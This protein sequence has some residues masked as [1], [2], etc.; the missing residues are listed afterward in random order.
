MKLIRFIIFISHVFLFFSKN[1]QA[2]NHAF[3]DTEKSNWFK[4]QSTQDEYEKSSG[5]DKAKI[6]L[7]EFHRREKEAKAR[8]EKLVYIHED[9][10]DGPK[11]CV[12]CPS[13]LKLTDEMSNIIDQ[14][15]INKTDKEAKDIPPK[16]S[17]LKFL[18]YEVAEREHD[19]INCNEYKHHNPK[20]ESFRDM[21]GEKNVLLEQMVQYHGIIDLYYMNSNAE[22][23]IYYYRG[24]KSE[25]N[26]IVRIIYDIKTKKGL[27][28]YYE[29]QSTN[30]QEKTPDTVALKN[31]PIKKQSEFKFKPELE[32]RGILPRDYK[33]AEGHY[34]EEII[35]DTGVNLVSESKIS[36]K[37]IKNQTSLKGK[38]EQDLIVM[39]LESSLSGKSEDIK[40]SVVLPYQFSIN[41]DVQAKGKVESKD[42]GQFSNFVMADRKFDYLRV[43]YNKNNETKTESY[44]I[45]QEYRPNS[46]ESFSIDYTQSNNSKQKHETVAKYSKSFSKKPEEDSIILTVSDAYGGRGTVTYRK[47]F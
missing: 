12:H 1:V 22:K 23:I 42:D 30:H 10:I 46:R 26:K 20:I 8:G 17:K 5:I 28:T 36:L 11:S 35:K 47:K 21:Q 45:G 18:Y 2:Q 9:E 14:I 39:S 29:I 41:E 15:Q 24:E 27:M 34:N 37:G 44:T 4:D 19:K 3:N 25:Q 38:N 7:E 13:Y 16:L 31:N 32:M 40:Y 43:S 6:I 33:I